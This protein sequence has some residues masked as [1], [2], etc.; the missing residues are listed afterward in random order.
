M[1]REPDITLLKVHKLWRIYVIQSSR[2]LEHA[3]LVAVDFYPQL[4]ILY[5]SRV[6]AL[7][8]VMEKIIL[9]LHL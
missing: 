3:C 8:D 4:I 1:K 5:Q 9:S 2:E 7:K 6:C